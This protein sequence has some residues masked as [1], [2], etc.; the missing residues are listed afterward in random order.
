VDPL[1]L[2]SQ[3][4]DHPRTRIL[5]LA[6]ADRLELKGDCSQEV[7]GMKIEEAAEEPYLH[8][9]LF[10]LS[11]LRQPGR[12]LHRFSEEV[13]EP[14]ERL[15]RESGVG[16]EGSFWPILFIGGSKSATNYHIDPTP[17]AIFHLFGAK[18]FHCLK[19]PDRWCP[20]SVKDAYLKEQVMPVRP[21]GV[22]EADCLVHDNNPGDLVWTPLLTPH[23]VNA[24]SLSATITFAVRQ[25][26]F[27]DGPGR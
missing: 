8:L 26:R 23:W 7:R 14:M 1:E 18:R 21:A 5:R 3:A 24:G 13:I 15:W 17:N 20:Q 19:E 27:G 22:Q 4:R 12:V 16:W 10:D 6:P 11:D 9:S 25:F 2:L